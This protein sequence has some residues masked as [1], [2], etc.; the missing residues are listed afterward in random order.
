MLTRGTQNCAYPMEHD[1][2]LI[3]YVAERCDILGT[4][5]LRH[6]NNRPIAIRPLLGA[7][8]R[9][10]QDAS[11]GTKSATSLSWRK[12][13]EVRRKFGL[14]ALMNMLQLR[15]ARKLQMR[16]YD[17]ILTVDPDT[18]GLCHEI[19]VH[20]PLASTGGQGVALAAIRARI[21]LHKRL[22]RK[23]GWCIYTDA[24]MDLDELA[25]KLDGVA[26]G[27]GKGR[28][29]VGFVMSKNMTHGKVRIDHTVDEVKHWTDHPFVSVDAEAPARKRRKKR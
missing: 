28:Q 22:H 8:W 16:Y 20:L 26:V 17:E 12:H 10:D 9:T 13:V 29:I 3:G 1:P 27:G 18:G 4:Q 7:G 21:A 25:R 14:T 24:N 2:A 23:R 15:R 5:E 11:S 6:R 19:A